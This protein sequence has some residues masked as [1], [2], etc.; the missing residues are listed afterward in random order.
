MK[1]PLLAIVATLIFSVSAFATGERSPSVPATE[2]QKKLIATEALKEP[3]I[4][5]AVKFWK[6]L[7]ATCTPDVTKADD[8]EN[9]G[10]EFEMRVDCQM[11]G[12]GCAGGGS[13]IY[14]LNGSYGGKTLF[15]DNI[16]I[17]RAG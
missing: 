6:H 13:T 5:A 3:M 9:E 16:K 12:D 8:Y 15:L 10:L 14:F 2:Q 1:S 7:G 17:D 4:R 11:P